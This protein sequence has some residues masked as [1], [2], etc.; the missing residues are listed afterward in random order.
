MASSRPKPRCLSA[1]PTPSRNASGI[2]NGRPCE[3]PGGKVL[4]RSGGQL[5]ERATG[6][7][8]DVAE[9]R[10]HLFFMAGSEF[11]PPNPIVLGDVVREHLGQQLRGVYSDLVASDLPPDLVRLIGHLE[12]SIRIPKGPRDPGFVEELLQST[13]HLRAFAISLTHDMDRAEDLV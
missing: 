3:T 1:I 4:N 5:R 10:P 2:P 12:S 8:V 11:R 6:L 7:P 9:I 13:R